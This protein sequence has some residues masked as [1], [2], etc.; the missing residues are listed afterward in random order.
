[1]KGDF[2]RDSYHAGSQ[3]SR[4]M[5]Q[6]GRVQLDADWNE[7]TAILLG[8]MRALTRDL[9]GP[10]AGP[11]GDCGFQIV[12]AESRSSL[13][14][15]LG[16]QVDAILKA[17]KGEL[18]DDDL[19]ILPGRYYVGGLP[20]EAGDA[21]RYRAQTGFPFGETPPDSL[22]Q[23]NW[24]A[25]LDVWE[26]Y[27]SA[28]QDPAIRDVALGGIDTCGR[29]RIR[30]Q[31]RLLL[32]IKDRAEFDALAGTGSGRIR[33][34]A[35]PSED[36]DELCSI[37]P[38]ARYRGAQNQLYRVEIQTGGDAEENG[39]GA[40]FK[41]SRDNGAIT[42][43]ILSSNGNRVALS[44]L[45]RDEATTLVEGNW[46]ELVD[47]AAGAAGLLAQV[48]K[49]ERDDMRVELSLP[50]GSAPLPTYSA[51]DAAARHALLRRWDHPG[52][53]AKSGGAIAIA[54]GTEIEL[55]DGVKIT[56]EQ[57]GVY[58][59]GD[60]W[61]IPARVVT[62]DVEWPGV[63]DNPQFQSPHGPRHYYAPL[64]GR[65]TNAAGAPEFADLRCCIQRLPC[66]NGRRVADAADTQVEAVK[67]GG[68]KTRTTPAPETPKKP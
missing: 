14:K 29:A 13:P 65:T 7:Q 64:A 10:A 50:D 1:M 57:G 62:G 5:M 54:E 33:A 32:D 19:L 42:F 30:W 66:S 28:D 2:S 27:V 23:R 40:T 31:V 24:L 16:A 34:R 12:S 37:A 67:T 22:R 15:E 38:D 3:Y 55:E 60:Y 43:P 63:P 45:G 53:R 47:D 44:H 18:G 49:V 25:Y 51:A 9:F 41:W 21:I 58:R 8:Y 52:E 20:V 56:F 48:A 36:S 59:P 4:V 26:D 11:A 35:N 68:S 39:S 17:D 61:L 46:V 6:Q